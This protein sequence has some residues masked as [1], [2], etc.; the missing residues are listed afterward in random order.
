MFPIPPNLAKRYRPLGIDSSDRISAAVYISHNLHNTLH[1]KP[2]P[3]MLVPVLM[4]SR[5]KNRQS[6]GHFSLHF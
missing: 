4:N 5:A 6:M 1:E 2:M 3:I